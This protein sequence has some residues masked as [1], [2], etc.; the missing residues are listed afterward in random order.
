MAIDALWEPFDMV[1]RLPRAVAKMKAFAEIVTASH[2]RAIEIRQDASGATI[3]AADGHQLCR[4]KAPPPEGTAPANVEPFLV[5]AR[6]F[7]KAAGDVGCSRTEAMVS[8]GPQHVAQQ[9]RPL[10][11]ARVEEKKVAIAG[12]EGTPQTIATVAGA[13]PD[14]AKIIDVIRDAATTGGTKAVARI[15]PRFLQNLADTAVAM[16]I[17]SVEITC[18]PRHNFIMAEGSGPDGCVAEFAIAGIGEIDFETIAARPIAAWEL[19]DAMTFTMPEAKPRKRSSS[20]RPK[21]RDLELPFDDI[22]F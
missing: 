18:S 1:I 11:V 13:M 9:D 8:S 3:T 16:G 4:I 2:D 19:D 17:T 21:A 10:V 12:P 15:D 6:A 20:R 14:C 22:P 5:D 7:S